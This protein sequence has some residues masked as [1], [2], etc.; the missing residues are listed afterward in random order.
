[1]SQ[2]RHGHGK[3]LSSS[4]SLTAKESTTRPIA[5]ECQVAMD[6]ITKHH[7]RPATESAQAT[8]RPGRT[9][10]PL[11][12]AAATSGLSAAVA[13]EPCCGSWQ[14][15]GRDRVCGRTPATTPGKALCK[16]PTAVQPADVPALT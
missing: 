16:K 9:A 12:W 5:S 1:M 14:A 4:L 13:A 7:A 6:R 8:A 10:G 2:A 15:E 3:F 11:E